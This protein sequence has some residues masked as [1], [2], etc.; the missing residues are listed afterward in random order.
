MTM[1]DSP[2]SAAT[3]SGIYVAGGSTT[4]NYQSRATK[5]V[6]FYLPYSKFQR[7]PKVI[8][9]NNLGQTRQCNH[10]VMVYAYSNYNT[11]APTLL[12]SGFN[13]L[14]INDYVKV[15]YYKDA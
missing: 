2:A 12:T 5:I 7:S 9:E 13:V 3:G 4:A 8:Y 1:G 11:T 10:Y 14:A 15:M 6:K